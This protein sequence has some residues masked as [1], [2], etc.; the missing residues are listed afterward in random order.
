MAH[1]PEKKAAVKADLIARN[2]SQREIGKRHGVSKA[3]VKSWQDELKRDQNHSPVMVT[4]NRFQAAIEEYATK[5]L[6]ALISQVELL[7]D[8]DFLQKQNADD[9]LKLTEFHFERL[10]LFVQQYSAPDVR[11]KAGETAAAG[12]ERIPAISEQARALESGDQDGAE[13]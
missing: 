1:A 9:I 8:K 4:E 6:A 10:Q 5:N 13:D 11:G 7:A 12:S 3:T 2:G